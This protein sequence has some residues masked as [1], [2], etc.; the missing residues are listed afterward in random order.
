[1]RAAH[2]NHKQLTTQEVALKRPPATNALTS[3]PPSLRAGLRTKLRSLLT[4]MYLRR[5]RKS[6]LLPLEL[7]NQ[8]AQLRQL[9]KQMSPKLEELTKL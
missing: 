6:T 2:L 9:R 3:F 8:A 7:I 5:K 4:I 1:L